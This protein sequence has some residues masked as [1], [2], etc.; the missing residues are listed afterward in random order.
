MNLRRTRVVPAIFH[1]KKKH[2]AQEPAT[3]R[4]LILRPPK[5]YLQVTSTEGGLTAPPLRYLPRAALI[6]LR[7]FHLL[8]GNGGTDKYGGEKFLYSATTW[9]SASPL[10]EASTVFTAFNQ[11][12]S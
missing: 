12:V 11:N 3:E 6:L 2:N 4:F 9:K 8:T 10:A 7:R 1:W 5:F